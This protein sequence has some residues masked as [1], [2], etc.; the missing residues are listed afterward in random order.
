MGQ[1][2]GRIRDP[3]QLAEIRYTPV[4]QFAQAA[5]MAAIVA[6]MFYFPLGA[7][8]AFVAYLAGVGFAGFVTFGGTMGFFAGAGLW[9]LVFFAGALIYAV[10]LF[11][12]GDGVLGWPRKK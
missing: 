10:C 4:A 7:L 12:W 2:G 6:T 11:P 8:L 5:L 1:E 9:W 3:A